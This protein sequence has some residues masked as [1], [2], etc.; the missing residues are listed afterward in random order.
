VV[1]T[2]YWPSSVI[3]LGQLFAFASQYSPSISDSYE[4]FNLHKNISVILYQSMIF[5]SQ[6]PSSVIGFHHQSVAFT[7]HWFSV[8]FIIQ[9][10]SSVI[11]FHHLSVAFIYN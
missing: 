4:I 10:P 9:W 3:G 2:T 5:I 6:Q 1:F 11:G 8:A 7:Y